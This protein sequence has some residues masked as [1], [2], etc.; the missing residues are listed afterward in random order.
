MERMLATIRQAIHEET[1]HQVTGLHAPAQD[2]DHVRAIHAVP[3]P[4]EPAGNAPEAETLSRPDF[5]R[6]L[7]GDEPEMETGAHWDEPLYPDEA[8]AEAPAAPDAPPSRN[9]ITGN[10]R[11]L[12]GVLGGSLKLDEA[13][14]RLNGQEPPHP[15]AAPAGAPARPEEPEEREAPPAP[16]DDDAWWLEETGLA[17]TVPAAHEPPREAPSGPLVSPRA[18]GAASSAFKRLR[19][20][21]GGEDISGMASEMLRPMLRAWLDEN[22]PA[23]VERL[24]REEI[25]RIARGGVKRR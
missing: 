23:L 10:R 4:E 1:A 7:S 11:M 16:G 18:A 21:L 8:E 24:V 14:A 12:G 20:E 5:L 2:Q 15:P 22:L 13:L 17:A 9:S 3:A 19:E 25:E 6:P